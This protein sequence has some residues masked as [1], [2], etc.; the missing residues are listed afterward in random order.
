M[1]FKHKTYKA[2]NK[3]KKVCLPCWLEWLEKHPSE[4]IEA[5]DLIEILNSL[6]EENEKII[7]EELQKHN[8]W[9]HYRNDYF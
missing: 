7:D 2:D 8:D 4:L 9:H 6:K 1:C 3:P 5:K